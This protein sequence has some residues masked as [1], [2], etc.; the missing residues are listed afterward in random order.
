MDFKR[1]NPAGQSVL[2][3]FIPRDLMEMSLFLKIQ[4]HDGM[5][6][7]GTRTAR[8]MLPRM[9][10]WSELEKAARGTRGACGHFFRD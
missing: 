5:V 2:K 9:E 10:S 8:T 7:T 1:A 6:Y 4:R 3:D